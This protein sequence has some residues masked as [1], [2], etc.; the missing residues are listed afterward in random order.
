MSTVLVLLLVLTGLELLNVVIGLRDE[1]EAA[2][3]R[4]G[5]I[6]EFESELSVHLGCP[7]SI[8]THMV[9]CFCNTYEIFYCSFALDKNTN[10][11]NK[12]CELV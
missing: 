12:M 4:H 5:L 3:W 10:I 6:T 11:L 8:Q 2:D 1:D 9:W 7:E